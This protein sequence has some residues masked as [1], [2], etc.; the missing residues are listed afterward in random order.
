MVH[1]GMNDWTFG[2]FN[3]QQWMTS[4]RSTE[5]CNVVQMQIL[6]EKNC[7]MLIFDFEFIHFVSDVSDEMCVVAVWQLNSQ[8]RNYNQQIEVEWRTN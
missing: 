6:G 2:V 8:I 5:Y 3:V 1:I 4:F 7:W